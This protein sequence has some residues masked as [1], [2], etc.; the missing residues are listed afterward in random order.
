MA[1]RL[2]NALVGIWLFATSFMWPHT[3]AQKT[4]TIVAAI[5]TFVLAI[6]AHFTPVARS[7][8]ACVA[9]LLFVMST[10]SLPTFRLAT[11]WNNTAVA[12]IILVISLVDDGSETVRHGR[13]VYGRD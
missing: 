13:D 11:L 6:L 8:N 2:L 9:I 12:V 3:P 7:L 1:I 4:V 10:M 5:L